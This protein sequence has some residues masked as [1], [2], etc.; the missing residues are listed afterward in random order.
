[1]A[2]YNDGID[3]S[4]IPTLLSNGEAVYEWGKRLWNSANKSFK[5]HSTTKQVWSGGK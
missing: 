4:G 2:D 1:M 5:L 3:M